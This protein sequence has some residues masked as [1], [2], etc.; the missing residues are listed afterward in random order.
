MGSRVKR[1]K[2]SPTRP[3]ASGDSRTRNDRLI[4]SVVCILLAGIV[5]IAFG[6]TL[7]HQFVNYDDGPYVYDNPRIISGL[8][9]GNI[10]WAFTHVH[11]ANWHPLT[12]I[13][14]M[15]DCQL[16]GLQPW[17]HHLTNILLH[18]AAAILLFFALRELTGG[19]HAAT[20]IGSSAVASAKADDAGRDQR[21]RLQGRG[22]LWASAF[23]AALFAIHPAHVESVAWVAE[24]KDVL[25]AVFFI[26][27]LWAY[28]RYARSDRFSWRRYT[29]VLVLFALGLMCKPTLVTLPLV[30]LLLDYW[31]LRRVRNSDFRDQRSA[32]AA[33]VR[34]APQRRTRL[35]VASA[36]QAAAWLHLIVE[37]IPLLV[38]SA[39]SCV[40]TILAQ[41]EAFAPTRAIPLQ[42]RVANAVV[43][44]V[45]YLGQAIYPAHL[46]VLY[47]Y[48]EGSLSVAQAIVALVFLLIVSVIFF[49]WR[50]ACPFALTGWFWFVGMLVPMIGIVQVGSQPRADR[51]TYLPEIGLYIVAT[52]GAMDLFKRWQHKREVFAV[53]LLIIVAFVTRSYFQTSYWRNSETLWRHTVDITSRNY[54]AHNNL[55]GTLLDRGQLGEAIAHYREALEIK[56]DVAQVQSN[57]GNALVR[58]GQVEEAIV[59][60]QKALEIDPGYAEAYNHMG[61]ALMKKGQAGEAIAYYQKAV[62]LNASYADA[63]NN[64]GVAF[65]RNGQVDEAIAHYRKAVAI[66]PGSAEMQYNL[67]NVLAREGNWADAIECYQ[68]ALSTERD[69]VKAA[70][71]RNNLGAALEKLGKSDEALEQFSQALQINGNYPEAHCNLGRMLAQRGRRDEAVAHLREALRLKPGY[72]EARKQLREL[73][74]TV[75]P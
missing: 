13:S 35:R 8:T 53:A 60:L 1:K 57:L 73:G 27:T 16:Y 18:A 36:W 50:K 21:S 74:V 66:N 7:H 41:K 22:S 3:A 39:A 14:H 56:P 11:A 15:L 19:G 25:S 26:L 70:K 6:Q 40:A 30:L 10:Q 17:G 62:Q 72:E 12:T 43:A 54:I 67:G 37:K 4:A 24:R 75:A 28:A 31:P 65:L 71:V 5:W 34:G 33:P 64:L 44:Y 20:G 69:S 29:T 68:A 47:P 55:A 63:Y 9:P 58:E 46:A 2:A 23:V 52:W 32:V 61:S 42:E 51:Y 38:L 45:E 59:H 49:V 48:P